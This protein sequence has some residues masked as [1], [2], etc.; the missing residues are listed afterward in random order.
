VSLGPGRRRALARVRSN[1]ANSKFQPKFDV[2]PGRGEQLRID[3]RPFWRYGLG[4]RSRSRRSPRSGSTGSAPQPVRADP[5]NEGLVLAS[6]Q[7]FQPGTVGVSPGQAVASSRAQGA[8]LFELVRPAHSSTNSANGSECTLTSPGSI[9]DGR[10]QPLLHPL[11]DRA[12]T[13]WSD[14]VLVATPALAPAA[15]LPSAPIMA[16]RCRSAPTPPATSSS[17]ATTEGLR[18]EQADAGLKIVH[19][20]G[21]D[22]EDRRVRRGIFDN[23]DVKREVKG[24]GPRTQRRRG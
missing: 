2:I 13:R 20:V 6:Q 8:Y 10:W 7:T 3:R 1:T 17:A 5:R 18:T 11:Q 14:V 21:P 12:S 15:G 9:P 22:S 24:T 16:C 23:I 19:D 4:C